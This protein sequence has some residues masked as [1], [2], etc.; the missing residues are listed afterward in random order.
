[1]SLFKGYAILL[2]PKRDLMKFSI[3]WKKTTERQK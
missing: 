2:Y 3:K 1:M